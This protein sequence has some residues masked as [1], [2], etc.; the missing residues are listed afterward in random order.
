MGIAF[1]IL[2]LLPLIFLPDLM[3][4]DSDD[5]D[6][7]TDQVNQFSPDHGDNLNEIA[8][9]LD[10][11]AE[12]G[13]GESDAAEIDV[14]APVDE[15]DLPDDGTQNPDPSS[16]LAPIDEDDE[17]IPPD[18]EEGEVLLPVDQIESEADSIWVNFNDDA[19]LGYSEIKD[20]QAGQDVLHVL[21]EPGSI[22]GDLDVDL[23]VSDDGLDALVYIEQQLVAILKGAPTA[24][25][26]DIIV[27]IGIIST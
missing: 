5:N 4:G 11:P 22:I 27:E 8:S 1:L 2:G 10:D 20:F 25:A 19:G 24:T 23:Q 15:D 16:V 14:L 7:S 13:A 3:H 18:S 21:V 26:A 17:S 9:L 6:A 12:D